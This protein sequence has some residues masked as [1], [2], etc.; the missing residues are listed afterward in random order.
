MRF[1]HLLGGG[2]KGVGGAGLVVQKG[3][4]TERLQR[5]DVNANVGT[6][7][8][9]APKASVAQAWRPSRELMTELLPQPEMPSSM[10]VHVNGSSDSAP[11]CA[12]MIGAM[13]W[14]TVHCDRYDGFHCGWQRALVT[15]NLHVLPCESPAALTVKG[16]CGR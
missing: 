13:Y 10:T 3:V 7:L 11:D 9:E 2:A 5:D 14:N 8:V 1:Q 16:E 12:C 15:Q 6:F 4:S